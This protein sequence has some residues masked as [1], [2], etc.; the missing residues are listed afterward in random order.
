MSIHIC[1]SISGHFW[2]NCSHSS[3]WTLP[4]LLCCPLLS[5]PFR[6]HSRTSWP[7]SLFRHSC[8]TLNVFPLTPER[9]PT[10]FALSDILATAHSVDIPSLISSL[11]TAPHITHLNLRVFPGLWAPILYSLFSSNSYMGSSGD[12]LWMLMTLLLIDFFPLCWSYFVFFG[13]W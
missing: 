3:W 10:E 9:H 13:T 4:S 12:T 6:C 11:N 2:L 1:L 8:P 7:L 5:L